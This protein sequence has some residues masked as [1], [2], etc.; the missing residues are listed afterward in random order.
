M[1]TTVHRKPVRFTSDPKRIIARFFF[2]GPES[3]VQNIIQRITEM[4][5][6]A[7]QLVLSQS[8]R[9]FSARHRNISK[10]YQ[11][12]FDRV[13][14]IMAGKNGDMNQLSEH[15]KML[16]GAY[17]TNEY[18]IESAAFFNPSM[19]EDPDQTGLQEGEKRVI[20][21]FRA[22]GEGHIS[23]IVFRGG[24]LDRNNNLHMKPTGKLVD[25][26][27]AIRNHVYQKE[28]FCTKLQ[29]MHTEDG[30]V[31]KVMDK[32]RFEFDYNELYNA[33]ESTIRESNPDFQQKKMLQT[34]TWLADSHYEIDFSLDTA[35]SERVI[36]PI[37]AAESN[38][39]ED[40]RFV[41][42]T[43]ND[44]S[45]KYYSTYT[46]YNGFSIMPKLVETKDFY[47]YKF[48]PIH[49]EN[50]QNKG[51][52]L[53][54]RKIN[55]KYAMLSRPDGINNY[56]MFSDDIN[57]WHDAQMIQAP[58]FPWEFI[59]IGNCGSPIETEYGWLVITHGVGTMRKYSLGATLLDL[60]DPTKV[61]G[62]LSEPMLTPNEEEREGYVPNVVYS[63]GSIIHNNE[64]VVPYAMSD[65]ASTF[66]SVPLD[67]LFSRLVPSQYKK[68]TQDKTEAKAR[69]L[70]VEDEVIN[71]KIISTI[72]KK[73]G[74]A[75]EVAPDGIVALMQIAKEKFDLILSD[76]AMPNFDGYQ[77]LEYLNQNNIDIPVVFISGYTSEEDEIKGLK[78]GAVEYIKKP[79]DKDL[80]LLRLE[81][82]FKR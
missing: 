50:A 46:A 36:F 67:D 51:M 8:L 42:F 20:I 65:T 74:Y 59:Q 4:P 21:S 7:A 48:M 28:A 79:I 57:L 38:G 68:G 16:I 69:I 62:Q 40:A 61:I 47:H 55:G 63:C 44:G 6:Q 31:D 23:S 73:A 54:P 18:S 27:E 49:G 56:I 80:L 81:K 35:I 75:V 25:E 12:H 66:A 58:K 2:P 64:L 77:L 10:I 32:L 11:K 26:A 33:V 43:E 3:R 30:I 72:L 52:A 53:F 1:S 9:D 76:I 45:V 37:A 34:V 15:K 5:D 24:I 78:M 29:E 17:F 70:V 71:Q 82:I 39:I 19:V 41:K 60:D 13:R 22:T 14:D